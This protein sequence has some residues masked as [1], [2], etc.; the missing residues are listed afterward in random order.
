MSTVA[1]PPRLEESREA[2]PPRPPAPP[3]RLRALLPLLAI[4]IVA[5]L[6]YGFQAWQHEV[7]WN[8]LDE[9]FYASQAREYAATGAITV[10]GQPYGDDSLTARV[11]SIAW[12]FDDPETDYLAAK[13]LNV[14]LMAA[15]CFPAYALARLV[16]GRPAAL[17]AAAGTVAIPAFV[18]AS[19]I[20]TEPLAYLLATTALWLIARTLSASRLTLRTLAWGAAAVGVSALAADARSQLYILFAVLGVAGALRILLSE[21]V[22]RRLPLAAAAWL[23]FGA[24]V[25]LG[26]REQVKREPYLALVDGYWSEIARFA[27]WGFGAL[28]IGVLVVPAVLGLAALWPVGER[29]RSPEHV[30][31]SLV[32]TV[33]ILAMA[34]YTGLKGAYLFFTFATRV[35]ERNMIYAAPLLFVAV[36][37]FLE[38]RRVN[39]LALAGSLALV[40][41][42]VY[43]VPYQLAFRI[44]SDA[45]GLAVLS[46]ANR[47]LRWTDDSVRKYL[48]VALA[49]SFVVAL[50]PYLVRSRAAL[51][52]GSA[53]LGVLFVA[54]ALTAEVA[55]DRSS[56]GSS[57]MFAANLPKPY[58]WVHEATGGARSV[59][60]G[61]AIA[62][63]NGIYLT[64]FFNPNLL[65]LASLDATAPLPG[66]NV[67]PD[68]VGSDGLLAPG[69]RD[70]R[71][72]VVDN[73]VRIAG[74]VIRRTKYQTLYEIDHPLRLTDASYGVS[75]DGWI[76][77]AGDGPAN[78]RYY[79]FAASRPGPGAVK[80]TVS[81]AAW[82]GEDVPGNIEIRV[83]PIRWVGPHDI[84]QGKLVE[85][86]PYAV[87]RL[88]IHTRQIVEYTIPVSGPPFVVDITVEPTFSPAD[89][90]LGDTRRLGVQP[91][92]EYVPGLEL[93]RVVRREVNPPA[94]PQ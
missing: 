50:L 3:R 7:P 76:V 90:G 94:I 77:G 25:Y 48:A 74:R 46:T 16:V 60:V 73:K 56:R 32:A 35:I 10:R 87:E 58:D 33:G 11:T 43:E 53:V 72:A 9:I 40:T 88:T 15:A 49:I 44:Y 81:R 13:L 66:P 47:H 68:I 89:F 2:P 36:A 30:A 54:G 23:A 55:A 6:V 78:G 86:A 63:P 21:P 70:A 19:M 1:D 18:Y 83:A 4:Y 34:W 61:I 5:C 38:R 8:F 24:I 57:T 12:H 75:G 28:A 79:Q 20:L 69:F 22:R 26:Y 71:Y 27:T 45:P 64:Q 39:P 42:A 17:F 37:I 85:G 29:R 14:L 92:F 82:G 91:G 80:V 41:Y 51:R 31:F 84:H 93:S 59:L 62:D 65:Y 52:L 67:T